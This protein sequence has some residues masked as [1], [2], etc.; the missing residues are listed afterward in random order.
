MNKSASG[1]KRAQ[2]TCPPK[3]REER[4]KRDP[5]AGQSTGVN[6][7]GKGCRQIT[8]P[9]VVLWKTCCFLWLCPGRTLGIKWA[10]STGL[11]TFSVN[12]TNKTR[13]NMA[14]WKDCTCQPTKSTKWFGA[15]GAQHPREI[16]SF[17]KP[18][19]QQ[20]QWQWSIQGASL[21]MLGENVI[22]KHGRQHSN[23]FWGIR[24]PRTTGW[25]CM[26]KLRSRDGWTVPKSKICSY[27]SHS[28]YNWNFEG[29]RF[30]YIQINTAQNQ[31]KAGLHALLSDNVNFRQGDKDS[32]QQ[33]KEPI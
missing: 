25:T 26:I 29:Y 27:T 31:N 14:F 23:L 33:I 4:D 13:K 20:H 18:H 24:G 19:W 15:A 1:L 6:T 10:K 7:D 30:K 11:R 9:V 21:L 22:Y 32:M 17:N 8:G 12:K 16:G 3:D 5:R 28:K 2:G